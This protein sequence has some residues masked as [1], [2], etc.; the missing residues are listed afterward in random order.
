MNGRM[1]GR[2]DA[3]ALEGGR[4]GCRATWSCWMEP[5]LLSGIE[6]GQPQ[7]LTGHQWEINTGEG[8][9]KDS[10]AE[11]GAGS[12]PQD[13]APKDGMNLSAEGQI[14]APAGAVRGSAVRVAAPWQGQMGGS[15]GFGNPIGKG[16]SRK[17]RGKE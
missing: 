11:E 5:A 13:H 4:V 8:K 1:N 17:R 6:K 12:L 3:E 10:R 15:C 16:P 2:V 7:R 9:D 14:C